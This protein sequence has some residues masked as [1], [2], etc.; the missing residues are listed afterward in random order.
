MLAWLSRKRSAAQAGVQQHVEPELDAQYPSETEFLHY[1]ENFGR[2][3]KGGDAKPRSPWLARAGLATVVVIGL[4]WVASAAMLDRRLAA[5]HKVSQAT[6][7]APASPAPVQSQA[8]TT[9]VDATVD[10]PQPSARPIQAAEWP[11]TPL[12]LPKSA[13]S[14]QPTAIAKA[15]AL[16]AEGDPIDVVQPHR[17]AAPQEADTAKS[18]LADE[19]QSARQANES[20]PPLPVVRTA[21]PHQA[22]PQERN[23]HRVAVEKPEIS[24]IMCVAGCNTVRNPSTNKRTRKTVVYSSEIKPLVRE[25][26]SRVQLVAAS[27][28]PGDAAASEPP[29]IM[30][31]AG[32][33]TSPRSYPVN[34]RPLVPDGYTE[35]QRTGII[36]R[37]GMKRRLH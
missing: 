28:T 32:C 37:R 35:P 20:S 13:P 25:R 5:N 9:L 14:I 29:A 12:I 19:E 16:P 11:T 2:R 34:I 27:D 23:I 21:T 26:D 7:N 30:C 24:Q 10:K 17:V 3:D 22:P 36:I 31:V 6:V 33:S 4:S 15:V 8:K 18:P 1:R